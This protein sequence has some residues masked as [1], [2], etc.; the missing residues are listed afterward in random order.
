MRTPESADKEWERLKRQYPDL[1]RALEFTRQRVDLGDRG[2]FYRVLAGPIP[3]AA[4]AER[5]C[6]ELR[7]RNEVCMPLKP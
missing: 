4:E 5:N 3:N 6:A 7:R 1:L 2:T